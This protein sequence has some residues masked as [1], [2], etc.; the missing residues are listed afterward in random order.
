MGA[1]IVAEER[2]INITSFKRDGT[3]VWCAQENGSLLVFSEA[4]SGKV[5]RIRHDQHVRITPCNARGKPRGKAVEADAVIL[6]DTEKV[7]MLLA[8]KYGWLWPAY[9][10]LM[11]FARRL[12]RQP[13]PKVVTIEITP[14]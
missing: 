10:L 14:R 8:K 3:P 7:R 12:R 4:G 6:E 11:A 2:Y 13:A 9:N 1:A 5:K